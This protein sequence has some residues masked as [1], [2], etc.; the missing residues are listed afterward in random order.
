MHTCNH[1][2]LSTKMLH[3]YVI[4]FELDSNNERNSLL[5]LVIA[6]WIVAYRFGSLDKWLSS[7]MLGSWAE[8]CQQIICKFDYS[9]NVI[10]CWFFMGCIRKVPKV[11]F[12]NLL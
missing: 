11:T 10:T 1:V 6:L 12:S 5:V 3:P 2:S 8:C 9:N 4:S 7:S